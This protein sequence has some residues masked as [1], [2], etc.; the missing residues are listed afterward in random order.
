MPRRRS[1]GLPVP[2]DTLPRWAIPLILMAG[3]FVG[4]VAIAV[5]YNVALSPVPPDSSQ[6]APKV[7][8]TGPYATPAEPARSY[9]SIG[10]VFRTRSTDGRG[11]DAVASRKPRAS[12]PEERQERIRLEKIMQ[13]CTGC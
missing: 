5:F 2:E 4:G 12:T 3:G 9:P 13:I 6:R 8:M 1:S 11:G 7:T 10:Q